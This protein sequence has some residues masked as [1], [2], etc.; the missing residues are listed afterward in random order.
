MVQPGCFNYLILLRCDYKEAIL[1]V[2]KGMIITDW[3]DEILS[4]GF[5][6]GKSDCCIVKQNNEYAILDVVNNKI[7]TDWYKEI[8][9]LSV[10]V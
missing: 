4:D 1:D 2:T 5:I 10:I 9:A 3:Y 6:E 8:P 7:I